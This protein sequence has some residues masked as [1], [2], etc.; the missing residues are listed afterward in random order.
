MSIIKRVRQ[1]VEDECKKPS[2]KYGYDPYLHHFIPVVEYVKELA[3]EY[4]ADEEILEISAWF[5]DIG[6]IMVGREDH[7]ITSGKIAEEKLRAFGYPEDRIKRVVDCIYTHR[8]SQGLK[9]ESIEA[10]IL[11]EADTLSAFRDI[12]GL[13][14]CAYVG[15]KLSR[16]EAKKSVRQKLE[17]KWKQLQF[18]K[19]R[20]IIRPKYEAAMLLLK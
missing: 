17:N 10:Q 11:V 12:T 9:P 8:G 6:S 13:F 18:K 16:E 5:H 20:E 19:S 14:Q 3:K 1:F 7:H 2:N 15:E 4:G